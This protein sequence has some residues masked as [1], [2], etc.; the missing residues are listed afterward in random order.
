MVASVTA[1]TD[2]HTA[3]YKLILDALF[4][5]WTRCTGAAHMRCLGLLATT[6]VRIAR[7]AAGTLTRERAWLVVANC[8]RR[9]R[10]D[11]AL[12]DVSTTVLH[13]W[14]PS[15]TVAAEARRHVVQ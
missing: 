1:L 10:I 12:V 15:V 7:H 4:S 3:A 2:A 6:A 11:R 9:T 5:S 8:T 14:F 13:T